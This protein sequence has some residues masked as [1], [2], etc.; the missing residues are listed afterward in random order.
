[1]ALELGLKTGIVTSKIKAVNSQA[2]QVEGIARNV[3]ISLGE[4]EGR[5]DF[6]VVELDDFDL[7]LG[8]PFMRS[9]GVGVFP[10]LEGILIANE[11]GASFVRGQRGSSGVK[12]STVKE[13]HLSAMQVTRECREALTDLAGMVMIQ[14]DQVVVVLDLL[15]GL[16]STELPTGS[17][18]K[19]IVHQIELVPGT[20]PAPAH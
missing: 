3:R 8:M 7:I 1:M 14:P 5:V 2:R 10:Q 13:E 11:A 18:E 16:Q 20:T 15:V 12:C 17:P 19:T 6:L 9:A 4:Y